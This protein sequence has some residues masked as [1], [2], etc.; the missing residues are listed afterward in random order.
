[1]K[2]VFKSK[3]IN[4]KQVFLIL[5]LVFIG[6]KKPSPTIIGKWETVSGIGFKMIYTFER[7]ACRELPEYFD[8]KFCNDYQVTKKNH[9]V[10]EF[11]IERENK[12][13]WVFEFLD[14]DG[15]IAEANIVSSDSTK[16]RLI[17]KRIK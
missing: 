12:E 11:T 9:L 8:T 15:D 2:N 7:D 14:D 1:M 5:L 17:L 10:T 16:Q 13:H 6:C 3:F 4:M